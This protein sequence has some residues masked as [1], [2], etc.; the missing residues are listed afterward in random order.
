M[1]NLNDYLKK[2]LKTLTEK[3]NQKFKRDERLWR[4][5]P[6]E[7][8]IRIIPQQDTIDPF[9]TLSFHYGVCKPGPGVLSLINFNEPDP[10][11]EKAIEFKTENNRIYNEDKDAAKDLYFK[12]YNLLGGKKSVERGRPTDRHHCLMVDR[13]NETPIL[14][15]WQFGDGIFENILSENSSLIK[16]LIEVGVITEDQSKDINFSDPVNGY[17]LSVIFIPSHKHKVATL[18]EYPNYKGPFSDTDYAETKVSFSKKSTPLTTNKELSDSIIKGELDL[19]DIFKKPTYEQLQKCLDRFLAN[20]KPRTHSKSNEEIKYT[21]KSDTHETHENT[22]ETSTEQTTSED[23]KER[24][25]KLF[26]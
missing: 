26:S 1:S 6:G 22:A 23:A 3:P 15:Y 7:N 10:I 8:K 25:K 20:Y 16:T 13:K 21:K 24:F 11:V 2:R 17:D 12:A 19:F 5:R 4:P 14:Q 9:V 18:K